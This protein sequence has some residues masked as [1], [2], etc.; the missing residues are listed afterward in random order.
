MTIGP[1][2]DQPEAKFQPDSLSVS[3]A[4]VA[5]SVTHVQMPNSIR[6]LSL[7]IV[8][9]LAGLFVLYWTRAVFIPFRLGLVF[10]YALP[11]IVN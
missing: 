1:A 6:S 11:L 9:V 4:L 8:A 2:T 7:A 10:G 3:A 5:P